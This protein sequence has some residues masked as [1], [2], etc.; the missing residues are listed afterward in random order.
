MA[1]DST[2]KT[3]ESLK[4][5]DDM[6][7]DN[8]PVKFTEFITN[9]Y[10]DIHKELY[11]DALDKLIEHLISTKAEHYE[12]Y[13]SIDDVKDNC[14]IIEC[15]ATEYWMP[16]EVTITHK[17]WPYKRDKHSLEEYWNYYQ[18]KED[19]SIETIKLTEKENIENSEIMFIDYVKGIARMRT[20]LTNIEFDVPFEYLDSSTDV[21]DEYSLS[22]TFTALDQK[23]Q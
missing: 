2:Y 14:K 23:Q 19:K 10:N 15:K 13:E 6:L 20:K 9:K 7:Y 12:N 21:S 3:N 11:E 18:K 22:N 16:S 17:T 1:K 8:R 5:Y 4:K